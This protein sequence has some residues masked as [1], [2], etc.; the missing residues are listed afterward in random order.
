MPIIYASI[1]AVFSFE[2]DF[3]MIKSAEE[4]MQQ[5]ILTRIINHNNFD[6]NKTYHYI[7]LGHYKPIGPKLY[8]SNKY[9]NDFCELFFNI[10]NEFDSK[11][12]L[13]NFGYM[14]GFINFSQTSDNDS[15][16]VQN[17]SKKLDKDINDWILTK[18]EVFPNPNSVLIHNDKIVLIMDKDVLKEYKDFINPKN[19]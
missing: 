18:A 14:S 6:K 9:S 15:Y 10:I 11:V 5:Q 19:N 4:N 13:Y 3:V 8:K 16:K 12:Y 2:K 1:I 17:I 7:Q